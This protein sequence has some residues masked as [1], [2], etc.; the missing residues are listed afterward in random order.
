MLIGPLIL[1]LLI[2]VVAGVIL[3]IVTLDPKMRQV[4]IILVCLI[5]VCLILYAFSPMMG[6]L[7]GSSARI[8]H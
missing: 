3:A 4:A 1:A 7:M 6:G 8:G 2:V 5:V